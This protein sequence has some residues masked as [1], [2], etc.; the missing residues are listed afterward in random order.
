MHIKTNNN[1]FFFLNAVKYVNKI[2]SNRKN[3]M[4]RDEKI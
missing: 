4:R 3:Q 2:L 1:F